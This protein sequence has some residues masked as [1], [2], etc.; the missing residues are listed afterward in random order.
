[1]EDLMIIGFDGR[2]IQPLMSGLGVYASQL[3]SALIELPSPHQFILWICPGGDAL[4]PMAR[5][6]EIRLKVPWPV[7]N[8][9][10]G[11]LWKQFSLPREFAKYR[12][13]VFHDP[14][15]QLPIFCRDV[16]MA[17]TIH[18]LSPFVMPGTNT[19]KYNTYWK[20]M[21]KISIHKSRH[22]VT[23]SEYTRHEIIERFKVN[24]NRITAVPLAVPAAFGP[25]EITDDTRNRYHLNQKYLLTTATFEPRK[26]LTRLLK[27]FQLFREG[28]SRDHPLVVAGRMGWKNEEVHKTLDSLRLTDSVNFIGYVPEVDLVEVIN[29]AEAVIVPSLYEGFGLTT[30]EAMACARPVVVSS[31]A[32]LPEVAGDSAVYF[33]P[34]DEENMAE[35]MVELL[36][37]ESKRIRMAENGYSRSRQFSWQRTA[38]AVLKIYEN[39]RSK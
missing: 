10:R 15:F 12:I 16:P 23:D 7:E 24:P 33:N 29:G 14:A 38:I 22:I 17:V 31:A 34:L 4:L 25:K 19:W 37:D 20:L 18:D 26:N 3:Y 30:L 8:H 11:D 5:S 9:T 6:N 28:F 36:S 1:M 35:K 39:L 27:A 13:G 32:S 2:R 21:T